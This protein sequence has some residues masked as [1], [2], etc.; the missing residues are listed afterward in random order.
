VL[1]RNY[2]F[3]SANDSSGNIVS[4]CYDN[5][6]SAKRNSDQP[7]RHRESAKR[8]EAFRNLFQQYMYHL[9]SVHFSNFGRKHPTPGHFNHKNRIDFLFFEIALA[10]KEPNC[11]LCFCSSPIHIISMQ[12]RIISAEQ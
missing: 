9:I 5:F 3:S 8:F 6:S 1:P 12:T 7:N 11:K 10:A 4:K 2:L